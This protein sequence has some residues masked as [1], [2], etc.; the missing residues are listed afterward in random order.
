M[1]YNMTNL[2]GAS[3]LLVSVQEVNK[4]SGYIVG[5]LILISLIVVLFISFKNFGARTTFPIIFFIATLISIL[6]VVVN[7]IP[8]FV[9]YVLVIATA[10][11]TLASI[12]I[13]PEG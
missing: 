9:V 11:L 7:L 5:F 3:N 4:L 10:G 12:F 1:Y 6:L 8:D 2:T 13:N